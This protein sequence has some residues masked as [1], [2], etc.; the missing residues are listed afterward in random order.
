MYCLSSAQILREL[1]SLG[2]AHRSMVSIGEQLREAETELANLSRTHD[3]QCEQLKRDADTKMRAIQSNTQKLGVL[4]AQRKQLASQ[5]DSLA[6][7]KLQRTQL[8]NLLA[9]Y[10]DSFDGLQRELSESRS[11]EAAQMPRALPGD[12]DALRAVFGDRAGAG[13]GSGAAA[14]SAPEEYQLERLEA[15]L[16]K[17]HAQLKNDSKAQAEQVSAAAANVSSLTSQRRAVEGHLAKLQSQLSEQRSSFQ[18]AEV[19]P[20]FDSPRDALEA[21]VLRADRVFDKANNESM[22]GSSAKLMYKRF[23]TIAQESHKCH[24]S[25]IRRRC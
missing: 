16:K 7:I 18:S 8:K 10:R 17:R 19:E 14:L 13:A 25:P 3:P 6:Q 1:E 23:I 4:S 22:L 5:A 24:V 11:A 15:A 9:S 12:A 21:E 20:L 2:S